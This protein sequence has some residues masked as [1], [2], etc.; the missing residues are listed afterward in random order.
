MKTLRVIPYENRFSKD[1]DD[2]LKRH[3]EGTFFH[4][5]AWKQAVE[6]TFGHQSRGLIAKRGFD[7]AGILPLFEI[8]SVLAGRLLVSIPY[9]TYGGI[10]AEN[11]EVSAALFDRAKMLARKIGARSIELRSIKASVS[12]L[13]RRRTHATFRKA[14]PRDPDEVAATF[15]RKARAAARRAAERYGLTVAFGDAHLPEVWRLYAR[16][17]RRLG[18]P[19]YPYRFFE[20]LAR[21]EKKDHVVQ[22]VYYQNRPVAGLLTF[23]HR[24][25]VM[26]YFAGVDERAGIYGLSHFLYMES[27]RWGVENGYRIYDFG[28]TRIDN[29]GPFQFKRHCGFEPMMLE[30][31]TAVMPGHAPPDLSP[32]SPRWIAARRVW[33]NL[34]LSITRPLGSWLAK[35]IP[36]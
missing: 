33:K 21:S 15:P 26:P 11:A 19:N 28:R 23:L 22:L 32:S 14:L 10:L 3:S 8:R 30:Y 16:S 2:F 13:E 18:S 7:V 35:S 31:Q 5:S 17:M 6:R 27:M 25:H 24:D 34:P 9:A 29:T 12:S 36:G 1:W 20:T 4:G